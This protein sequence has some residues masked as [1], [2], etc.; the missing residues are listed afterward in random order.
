MSRT[1]C[2]TL[3]ISLMTCLSVARAETITC[4]SVCTFGPHQTIDNLQIKQGG[5][6]L[7]DGTYVQGSIVVEDGGRLELANG[8]TIVGN[9]Q[10]FGGMEVVLR[11]AN[12]GGSVQVKNTPSILIENMLVEADIQLEENAGRIKV[13]ANRMGGNLQIYKNRFRQQYG[14]VMNNEVF[15][16]LQLIDNREGTVEVVG[17]FVES[18]LQCS[19]NRAVLVGH[20]NN[21]GDLECVFLA[22][23]GPGGPGAGGTG[24]GPGGPT[25]GGTAL[26]DDVCNSVCRYGPADTIENLFVGAGGFAILNGTSVQGNIVVEDGGRLAFND[27][28]VEGNVQVFGGSE[29]V[30]NGGFVGRSVQIKYTPGVLVCNLRIEGDLQLEENVGMQI[31]KHN[32]VRGN[33]QFTKNGI[34]KKAKILTNV[35]L[36]NLQVVGNR[37]GAVVITGN[38]V[39]SALQCGDNTARL[40]GSKNNAG[41]LECADLR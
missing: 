4:T 30:L 21:A 10:S 17:N 27:S 26:D 24:P 39:A 9:V 37:G 23:G 33:L 7:L 22:G 11:D 31:L 5:S 2:L 36:G 40:K 20:S 18:A 13:I 38:Q 25:D 28:Q 1:N 14:I 12:V 6:A 34:V 3:A 16:N 15:G 29:V 41:D 8:V 19:D 32:E 35:V